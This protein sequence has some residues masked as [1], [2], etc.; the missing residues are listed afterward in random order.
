MKPSKITYKLRYR[1]LLLAVSVMAALVFRFGVFKTIS[2]FRF[3]NELHDRS[4]EIGNAPERISSLQLQIAEFETLISG[5]PNDTTETRNKI[6]NVTSRFCIEN[7]LT[8]SG[9]LPPVESDRGNFIIETNILELEG[10]YNSLLQMVY[11]LEKVW[12]P[13]KIVSVKYFTTEE[14]KTKTVKLYADVYIQ[15]VKTNK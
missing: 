15:K 5:N 7:G 1:L 4:L 9:F 14:L 8:L 12:K 10:S 6:M 2:A 13:G 11:N 3:K